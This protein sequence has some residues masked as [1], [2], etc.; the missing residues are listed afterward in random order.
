MDSTHDSYVCTNLIAI[1]ASCEQG[2]GVL[3]GHVKHPNSCNI[4]FYD[5]IAIFLIQCVV[6]FMDSLQQVPLD[7]SRG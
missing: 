6:S 1:C 7:V 4:V 5:S 3:P 2:I